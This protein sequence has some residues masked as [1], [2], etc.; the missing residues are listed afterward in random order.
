LVYDVYCLLEKR[1]GLADL[2]FRLSQATGLL[3]N[4]AD[5]PLSNS[6]GLLR[7]SVLNSAFQTFHQILVKLLKSA[8]ASSSPSF[9]QNT[10]LSESFSRFNAQN[11]HTILF[12]FFSFSCLSSPSSYKISLSVSSRKIS[13]TFLRIKPSTKGRKQATDFPGTRPTH[14]GYKVG[15]GR[16]RMRSSSTPTTQPVT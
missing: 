16:T 6:A 13:V 8:S 5:L 2:P 9:H 1:N 4:L 11:L 15:F 14:P 12:F 3:F 10:S 7:A